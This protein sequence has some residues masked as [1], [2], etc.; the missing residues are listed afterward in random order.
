MNSTG[1]C[2]LASGELWGRWDAG[3]F[4][5]GRLVGPESPAL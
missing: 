4:R 2:K 3:A 1:W 5:A